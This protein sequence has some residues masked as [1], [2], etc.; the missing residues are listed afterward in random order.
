MTLRMNNKGFTL[1]ETLIV[2]SIMA[3]TLSMAY[4]MMGGKDARAQLKSNSR[5][6]ASHM[7]VARTGAIRDSQPWAIQFDSVNGR[8]LIYNDSGEAVG[9]E[10]WS[11]GDES[12]YRTVNLD[13]RVSYGSAQG[14]RTGATSLPGDGV[15]FSANR[16]VFN[17]NGTSES[18]TVYLKSAAGD[19][20]AVSSLA[21]TGRVKIWSN[22][23]SGWSN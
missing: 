12:I 21:T 16:V 4:F 15:S 17:R 13:G 6:I 2:I 22:Y 8:Y 5:D 7:K 10:D 9:S 14:M 20:F 11:D 1:I 19:T 18:G 3:I 23:G